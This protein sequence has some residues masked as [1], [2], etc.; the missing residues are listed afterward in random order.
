MA[1]ATDPAHDGLRHALEKLAA[2]IGRIVD[3]PPA[4]E[5]VEEFR[6]AAE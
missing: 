4:D 3:P 2:E 5:K 1:V 6:K